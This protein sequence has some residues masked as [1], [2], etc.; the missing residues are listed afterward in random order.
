MIPARQGNNGFVCPHCGHRLGID[1]TLGRE[2][3]D[4]PRNLF[5]LSR[6]WH[7]D[8]ERATY[9]KP[10]RRALDRYGAGVSL[11]PPGPYTVVCP[12]CGDDVNIL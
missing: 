11:P 1:R 4:D 9:R 3:T 5:M 8:G 7:W 10:H 2:V 12:R 6:G